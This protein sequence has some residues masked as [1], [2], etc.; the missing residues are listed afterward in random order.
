[1][2]EAV[3]A[4]LLATSA[5]T[6]VTGTRINFGVHP[7]GDPLPAIVLNVVS[8]LQ[9]RVLSGADGLSDAQV[10]VDCYAADYGTAKGLQRSVRAAL[11]GYAGGDIQGVIEMASRDGFVGE[12][13][14]GGRPYRAT[15]DFRVLYNV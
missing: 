1:M 9:G 10:Q 8:D 14:D 13:Q 15:S 5:I 11:A 4:L 12:T 3:R 7:Q 6:D 2:E